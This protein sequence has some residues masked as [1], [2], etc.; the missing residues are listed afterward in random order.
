VLLSAVATA[1]RAVALDFKG[2]RVVQAQRALALLDAA[3][4]EIR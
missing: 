4:S 3:K 2:D 1:S